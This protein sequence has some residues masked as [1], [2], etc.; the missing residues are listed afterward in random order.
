[1]YT[2]Q[3][4]LMDKVDS[5]TR[6][7]MMSG[8]RDRDTNPELL[9]R[10]GLQRLGFRHRLGTSYRWHGKLLPGRPD[11]VFPKYRAVIQVNG[12]FW[13]CHQCHL[14]KWPKTRQEFW[15]KKLEDNAK[16]DIRNINA[17]EEQGWRVL[18]LWECAIKGKER[19]NPEQ[20]IQ[21]IEDW[22]VSEEAYHFIRGQK[23]GTG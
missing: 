7:R 3:A 22:L 9:V 12:C 2:D 11:L 16:R 15:E 4:H 13:H 10:S 20:I 14:F 18:T 23:N 19:G 1:M 8:I 6:S 21:E 5:R 17:L